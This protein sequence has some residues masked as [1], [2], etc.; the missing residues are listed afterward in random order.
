M[1]H[2]CLSRRARGPSAHPVSWPLRNR[3][4]PPSPP[5]CSPGLVGRERT[6]IAADF[7]TL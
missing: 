7:K 3:L 5:L 4:S 2:L 1:G 6:V